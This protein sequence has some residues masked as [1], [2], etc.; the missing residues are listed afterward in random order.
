MKKG[1]KEEDKGRVGE[2]WK[3][4]RE[5]IEGEAR[6]DKGRVTLKEIRYLENPLR[7]WG[8]DQTF[9]LH[10]ESVLLYK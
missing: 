3:A 9:N 5:V 1:K 6:R 8:E 4:E 10:S 7:L 2:R